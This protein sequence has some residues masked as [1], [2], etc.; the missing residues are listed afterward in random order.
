MKKHLRADYYFFDTGLRNSA[1]KNFNIIRFRPDAPELIKNT[2]FIQLRINYPDI[3]LKYWQTLGKAEVDFVLRKEKKAVPI[4]VSY[5]NMSEPKITRGF[6][7]FLCSYKPATALVLT[8]GFCGEL[9]VN[10]SLIK[11]LP[12]WY[13]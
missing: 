1:L 10:S 4:D 7:N 6:R 3:P 11:F 2:A 12:V 8:R 13:I 5:A 9:K